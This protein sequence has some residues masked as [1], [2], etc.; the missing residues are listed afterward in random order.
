MI[1]NLKDLH[2]FSKSKESFELYVPLY[3]W[4]RNNN[5]AL[6]LF[7]LN[8]QNININIFINSKNNICNIGHNRSIEV[9]DNV[10]HFLP[11]EI[12]EQKID[13]KIATGLFLNYDIYN[14][15][16]NYIQIENE[17]LIPS[18]NIIDKNLENYKIIGQKS[19]FETMP[20]KYDN[21]TVSTYNFDININVEDAKLI[22]NYIYISNDEKNL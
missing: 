9:E 14:K 3:F 13:N 7:N 17:F 16:I 10:L 20:K 18:L 11:N 19:Q 8:Y 4:F 22:T 2:S 1:G 12:I 21:K 5:M 15:I 6:P